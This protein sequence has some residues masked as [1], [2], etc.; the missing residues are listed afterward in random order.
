M[1][2][3]TVVVD[4]NVWLDLFLF[5]DAAAAALAAALAGGHVRAVRNQAIDTELRDILARP[6]LVARC[7][8]EALRERLEKWLLATT[9]LEA[10]EAA[11]W[12]C[13]DPQDQK[14]LDLAYIAKASYLFTKDR[15]LLDVDRKSRHAGLRILEPRNFP[16]I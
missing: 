9:C 7:A 1:Q 4:T 13:R 14:F 8:P 15:A 5:E 11:P 12:Q 16:G 10:V 3:T 2:V 6:L